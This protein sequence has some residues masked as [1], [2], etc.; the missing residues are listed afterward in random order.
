[1]SNQPSFKTE[2]PV[3]P[4][5]NDYPPTLVLTD[6]RSRSGKS[7]QS[8]NLWERLS[9]STLPYR[10]QLLYGLLLETRSFYHRIR[11]LKRQGGICQPRMGPALE[12]ATSGCLEPNRRTQARIQDMQQWA[13]SRPWGSPSDW[14]LFLVGWD[15]GSEYSEREGHADIPEHNAH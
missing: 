15:A 2:A 6:D 10:C 1:L 14:Q 5:R 11:L 9:L 13:E 12:K 7:N 3:F 8:P 4:T